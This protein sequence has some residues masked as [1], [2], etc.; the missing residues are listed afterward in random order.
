VNVNELEAYAVFC[1]VMD[2][3]DLPERGATPGFQQLTRP[4]TSPHRW[5]VALRS[6]DF[7][8]LG[9]F[10]IWMFLAVFA[11]Y[12]AIRFVTSR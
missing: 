9:E 10:G 8:F 5:L 1:R 12:F 11:V 3:P 4:K 7:G 2:S 6:V